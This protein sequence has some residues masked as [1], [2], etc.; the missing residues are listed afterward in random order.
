MGIKWPTAETLSNFHPGISA[1]AIIRVERALA[2]KKALMDL[3]KAHPLMTPG[4]NHCIQQHVAL[5]Q[6]P[7]GTRVQARYKGGRGPVTKKWYSG[8]IADVNGNGRYPE[9]YDGCWSCGSVPSNPIMQCPS[10]A[11]AT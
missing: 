2:A 8:S 7:L 10:A 1:S 6:L 3:E 9:D 5:A 11:R 4:T